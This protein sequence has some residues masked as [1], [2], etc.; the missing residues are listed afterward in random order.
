MK[1]IIGLGNPGFRYRNTRHNIGF[2]VVRRI[3]KEFRI[4]LKKKRYKGILGTGA[5]AGKKTTLFMPLTYMNLSGEAVEEI[6]NTQ[7]INSENT[8][9]VCDD[10]NLEFGLIRL[11]TKGSSG[12]HKGLCSVIEH[13][14]TNEF[15]RLR[16]GIGRKTE[17]KD[18]ANFVLSRFDSDERLALRDIIEKAVEC[19]VV[20]IKLGPDRAMSAF[21]KRQF[22]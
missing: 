9:V 21:N 17:A 22:A 19:V 2:L 10:I 15:P 11:R 13:L 20:W 7:K 18:R 3:A 6:V 4:P 14:G 8:L 5:I 16:I 1:L 12:G